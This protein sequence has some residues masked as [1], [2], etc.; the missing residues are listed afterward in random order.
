MAFASGYPEICAAEMTVQAQG[1]YAFVALE[2]GDEA[3]AGFRRAPL[4]LPWGN[5]SPAS[6]RRSVRAVG[7]DDVVDRAVGLVEPRA[8]ITVPLETMLRQAER[9]L[10]RLLLD[11]LVKSHPPQDE[12]ASR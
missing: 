5:V 11:A 8:L 2:F 6:G 7:P 10:P 3:D 9:V 4:A 12:A 1:E